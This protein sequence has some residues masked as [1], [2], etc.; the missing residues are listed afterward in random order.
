VVAQVDDR[1]LVD[2]AQAGDPDAY[3]TLVRRYQA[4]V[5]R[6]A[7]R[8]LQSRA[9]ADDVTQET[10]VRA[11][12]SL[13]RFRGDSAFSTWLYRIV[14]RRCFDLL[15]AR[16]P[17]EALSDDHLDAGADPAATVE[18]RERLHA[19]ARHIAA[20]PPD[21]RAALV[22]REFEGLSYQDVADVLDTSVPAI[23]GRIHRAR[24]TILRE[25][26]AWR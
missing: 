20:L 17:T 12:R 21:Q 23:K 6:I 1:V 13:S 16:R 22:L 8:L 15:G 24:L 4:G 14:T 7:L 9:D 2:A 10:F 19:V 25:T 5:Y 26:A 18:Q 11:W 3:E